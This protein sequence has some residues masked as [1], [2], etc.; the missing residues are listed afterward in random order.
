MQGD[1]GWGHALRTGWREILVP[2]PFFPA[3]RGEK[4]GRD[5]LTTLRLLFLWSATAMSLVVVLTWR[6]SRGV[7]NDDPSMSPG[8]FLA[9]L[10]AF[11]VLNLMLLGIGLRKT[12]EPETDAEG[13]AGWFR[14]VTFLANS[15]VLAPFLMGFVG[16]FITGEWT[17]ALAGAPVAAL[18]WWLAAPTKRRLRSAQE[19]LSRAGVSVD[20]VN[21]LVSSPFRQGVA[22][23]AGTRSDAGTGTPPPS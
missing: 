21:A 17:M 11:G 3:R 1:P 15:L 16:S 8:V 12:P 2:F 10:A 6:V 7:S 4:T 5:S 19:Q 20:L 9:L 13:V 23:G 22:S 14:T 18:V